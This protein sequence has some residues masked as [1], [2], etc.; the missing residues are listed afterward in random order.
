M[1]DRKRW[2]EKTDRSLIHWYRTANIFTHVIE[3]CDHWLIQ[4]RMSVSCVVDEPGLTAEGVE[5]SG[6]AQFVRGARGPQSSAVGVA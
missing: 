6:V 3:G 4:I 1:S 5:E 2:P